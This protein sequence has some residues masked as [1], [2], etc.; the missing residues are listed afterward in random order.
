MAE[1][2]AAP[3]TV[4][5]EMENQPALE[6]VARRAPAR[7][8][9]RIG[10]LQDGRLV[11]ERLLRE[12]AAVSIG[13]TAGDTIIVPASAAL[14]RSVKLFEATASGYLLHLG[15][16]ME[17]TFSDGGE[18]RRLAP[19]ARVSLGGRA[20]GRVVVGDLA[21]LFQLI[22][23]PA[24]APRA[25]LPPSLRRGLG[26]RLDG[27]MIAI[28]GVS[29]LAHLGMVAYLHQLDWP[30]RPDFTAAATMDSWSM[31]RA[32]PSP[33][34]VVS[35][36]APRSSAADPPR[37][38]GTPS[39]RPLGHRVS[40]RSSAPP[41]PPSLAEIRR[42]GALGVLTSSTEGVDSIA[43]L[44]ARGRPDSDGDGTF[45]EVRS[46]TAPAVPGLGTRGLPS[47]PRVAAIAAT[48]ADGP[49]PVTSGERR[50]EAV[51]VLRRSILHSEPPLDVEGFDPSTLARAL[52]QRKGAFLAC[53]DR[54]L[55]HDRRLAGKLE[56]H[57]A[58]SAIGRV[59]AATIESDSLGDAELARCI[60]ASV[61][62]WQL[63]P[64][65]EHG[66]EFTC[67]LVFL[68]AP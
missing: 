53:Y 38:P 28:V 45:G 68:P 62:A 59:T 57:V 34:H 58:V 20:R 46:H 5:A 37:P 54:A 47:D 16:G 41:A 61:R 50:P 3:S 14:P 55:K 23:L 12:R 43:D 17:A 18:A 66:G 51:A 27:A 24:E 10:V 67:P 11:E 40:H 33:V 25:P 9:L 32:L 7:E 21:L 44:L 48:R 31:P 19:G 64:L 63:P 30:R 56:L 52:S 42:A 6:P 1:T 60:V 4:G 26:E 29:L 22:D 15:A 2:E 49:T 65:G 8:G 36:R 35:P 39:S 13:P